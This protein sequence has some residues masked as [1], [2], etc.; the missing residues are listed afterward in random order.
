MR[1]QYYTATSI[2]G[3]IADD[4]NSLEWLFQ[5]GEVDSMDDD[6]PNFIAEVGAMAMGSTTFRWI[7][8]HE[9]L[10]EEA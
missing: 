8:E 10:V 2:D 1:T 6:Y 4:Q 5:F 9:G 3:F 7:V